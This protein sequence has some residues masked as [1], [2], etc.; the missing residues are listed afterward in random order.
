MSIKFS[1]S[2]ATLKQITKER[3]LSLVVFFILIAPFVTAISVKYGK[4]TIGTSGSYNFALVGPRSEWHP[5]FSQVLPPPN[6]SANSVWEDISSVPMPH[7]SPLESW[8]SFVFYFRLVKNNLNQISHYLATVV[9]PFLILGAL[10]LF[11]VSKNAKKRQLSIILLACSLLFICFYGLVL[12]EQRY[13]WFV[14]VAATLAFSGYLAQF[15]TRSFSFIFLVGIAVLVVFNP[16]RALLHNEWLN[17]ETRIEANSFKPY[18]NASSRVAS[19]DYS[20]VFIC[21]YTDAKCYSVVSVSD[22]Q[23]TKSKLQEFGI[24]Y[25]VLAPRSYSKLKAMDIGLTQVGE[26][27][28]QGENLYKVTHL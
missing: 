19:D 23:Y 21:Y 20:S 1:D 25:L 18:L 2:T 10:Y 7:W 24:Q 9:L 28:W 3:L 17:K 11:N 26:S 5:M 16:V 14:I 4:P 12:F 27:W 13:L 15:K 22:K 6:P 8:K